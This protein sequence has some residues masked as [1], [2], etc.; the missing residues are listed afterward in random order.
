MNSKTA[1]SSRQPNHEGH[2]AGSKYFLCTT[3]TAYN[4]THK[5]VLLTQA[6][7][8]EYICICSGVRVS[9]QI[10][11]SSDMRRDHQTTAQPWQVKTSIFTESGSCR[12]KT[13][14]TAML[15]HG[16]VIISKC[17]FSLFKLSNSTTK[18]LFRYVEIKISVH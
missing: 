16:M 18:L 5:V 7:H 10:P 6:E 1:I 8:Y 11:T 9:V 2:V 14:D 15:V 12:R 13:S 17:I 3:G 4:L